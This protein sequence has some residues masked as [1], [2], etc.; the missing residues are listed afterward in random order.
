MWLNAWLL[1]LQLL[2]GPR[3][4]CETRGKPVGPAPMHLL[5]VGRL[6]QLHQ[7]KQL[8]LLLLPCRALEADR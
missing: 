3:C 2:L 8:L 4:A 6:R 5:A 7:M 1:L